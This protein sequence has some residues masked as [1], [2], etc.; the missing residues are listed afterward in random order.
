MKF[1]KVSTN[2]LVKRHQTVGQLIREVVFVEECVDCCGRDDYEPRVL[3]PYE[4]NELSILP[5]SFLGYLRAEG[6]HLS[7]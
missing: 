6:N 4:M 5:C 3:F 7:I 1:F 2:H